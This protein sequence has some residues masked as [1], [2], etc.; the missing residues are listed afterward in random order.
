MK[1]RVK[2]T[3]RRSTR[4]R[5]TGTKRSTRRRTTGSKG[6]A[7][8]GAIRDLELE[9]RKLNK[10]KAELKRESNEAGSNLDLSRAQ[11]RALQG[12]IARIIE[13]QARLNQKR[14]SLQTRIDKDA[15]KVSKIVKIKS[16][17]SDI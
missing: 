17:I 1:K 9:I 6:S 15:E 11:E 13:S 5:T 14:K 8:A 2:R 7:I 10:D 3:V 12:R 4:R 16:E